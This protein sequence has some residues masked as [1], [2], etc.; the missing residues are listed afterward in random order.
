MGWTE[1]LKSKKDAAKGTSSKAGE[2]LEDA[3]KE[4][5]SVSDSNPGG[6]DAMLL[7]WRAPLED[8]SPQVPDMDGAPANSRKVH[9]FSTR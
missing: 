8:S 2:K 9:S 3:S 1:K 6:H 5:L 4:G 7:S